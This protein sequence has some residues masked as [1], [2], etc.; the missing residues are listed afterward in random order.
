MLSVRT[1]RVDLGAEGQ[2]ANLPGLQTGIAKPAT[3]SITAQ[4]GCSRAVSV[5]T[6][7]RKDCLFSLVALKIVPFSSVVWC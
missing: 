7:I 5:S 2:A 4:A 1:V 3:G 6:A